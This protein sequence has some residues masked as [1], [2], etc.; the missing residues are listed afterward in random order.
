MYPSVSVDQMLPQVSMGIQRQRYPPR[1]GLC[2]TGIYLYPNCSSL[3]CTRCIH[4]YPLSRYSEV[5]RGIQ[6]GFIVLNPPADPIHPSQ[7]PLDQ[8]GIF[9]YPNCSLLSCTRCIHWNPEVSRGIHGYPAELHCFESTCRPDPIPASDPWAGLPTCSLGMPA[10]L[11]APKMGQR[12]LTSMNKIKVPLMTMKI[13]ANDGD[14][15]KFIVKFTFY[16]KWIALISLFLCLN[17]NQI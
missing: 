8:S 16:K 1:W 14:A 9:M 10:L 11:S 3:S 15:I 13:S 5:S 6:Q 17:A 2:R 4:R 12:I 7:W